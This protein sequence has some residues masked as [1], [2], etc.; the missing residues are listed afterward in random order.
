[1][2]RAWIGFLH[3]YRDNCDSECSHSVLDEGLCLSNKHIWLVGSHSL[4]NRASADACSS[5]PNYMY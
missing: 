1:M 4:P 5:S 2:Y 3:F